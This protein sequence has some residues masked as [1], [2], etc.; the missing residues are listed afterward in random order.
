MLTLFLAL[1]LWAYY[2]LVL[3]PGRRSVPTSSDALS[4]YDLRLGVRHVANKAGA[5]SILQALDRDMDS[6]RMDMEVVR[7]EI[8][9]SRMTKVRKRSYLQYRL[10]AG[11]PT[12]G[13]YV[14]L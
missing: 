6:V 2:V 13:P 10:R 1:A 14:R 7:Q 5:R 3:Q 12:D 4:T 11:L 9:G 8:L